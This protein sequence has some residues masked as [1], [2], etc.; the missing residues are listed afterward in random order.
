MAVRKGLVP[1]D[2]EQVANA[3]H[4]PRFRFVRR[5]RLGGQR[6]EYLE[7]AHERVRQPVAS[8][9]LGE[10]EEPGRSRLFSQRLIEGGEVLKILATSLRGIP[11]ST[12]SN[13]FSLRSKTVSPRIKHHASRYQNSPNL[14]SPENSGQRPS[15][16][17]TR[18]TH[19]KPRLRLRRR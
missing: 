8:A 17:A 14:C 10:A 5:P 13:T 3:P 4:R 19:G 2:P 11:R 6:G 18:P 7:E 9:V 16:P 15:S 12:A 1:L